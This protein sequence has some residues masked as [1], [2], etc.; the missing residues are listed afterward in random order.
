MSEPLLVERVT[1]GPCKVTPFYYESGDG[2]SKRLIDTGFM[3]T[4]AEVRMGH[5]DIPG[6]LD[7]NAEFIA[8]CFTPKDEILSALRKADETERLTAE[9][10]PH[11]SY[12]DCARA[13]LSLGD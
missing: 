4:I 9:G 12:S 8:L 6:D 5:D 11:C 7:A 3:D 2:R 10:V 1:P 13:R